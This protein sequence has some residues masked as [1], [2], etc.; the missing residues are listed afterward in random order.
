[1]TTLQTTQERL[2]A[3]SLGIEMKRAID[4]A[5]LAAGDMAFDFF[6]GLDPAKK[7][8]REHILVG[9][10][11][12]RTQC[13]ITLDYLCKAREYARQAADFLDRLEEIEAAEHEKSARPAATGTGAQRNNSSLGYQ[14]DGE[15]ST[16]FGREAQ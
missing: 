1:M 5:T 14:K 13:D 16:P 4:C 12:A 11:R 10:S 15:K 8:D 2:S 6:A 7:E 3:Q 9:F